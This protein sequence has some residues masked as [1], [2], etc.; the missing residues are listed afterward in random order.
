[1]FLSGFSPRK[2]NIAIYIMDGVENY[3]S[4]LQNTGKYKMEKSCFY[5]NKLNDIDKNLLK[6]MIVDS[7]NK[8]KKI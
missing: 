3:E 7:V 4:I 5:I 6:K 8:M 1:M 2:H